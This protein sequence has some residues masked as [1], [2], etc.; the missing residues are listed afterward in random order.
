[1]AA[2]DRWVAELAKRQHGYVT[3]SQLLKGGLGAEAIKYRIRS[4]RLIRV[5][6]GVYAVG[7]LPTV[8]I[9]RAHAALLACGR[10]AVLAH[11]SAASGWGIFTEWRMPFEVI[12]PCVR[13]HPGIVVHRARLAR[14]DI[15]YT[16][17]LRLTSP[18]RTVLD[19]APRLTPRRLVRAVDDLRHAHLIRRQHLADVVA[20][21]PRHPGAARVRLLLEHDRGPS[22]SDFE[23]AFLAFCRQ[24]GLPEPL[25]NATVAEREVDA[26]FPA[27][28]VIVELDS[29]NFHRT[30]A[31]FNSDRD[32]DADMLTLDLPTLRITWD[33]LTRTPAREAAR[34]HAILERRRRRPA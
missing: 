24:H 22:R 8:A 32:R 9:D 26:Y 5:Y 18:A 20:R 2:D 16:L 10:D 12:V 4:G 27:E 14:Q 34:L 30:R 7:H 6:T 33:R 19:L 13:R 25:I 15:R 17:G 11:G 1:M 28:R 29:W 23:L 21:Y 31:S 3:R